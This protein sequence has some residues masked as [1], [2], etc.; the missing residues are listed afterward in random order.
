MRLDQFLKVSRLIKRRPLG[1]KMCAAG[2]VLLNG[3]KAKAARGVRIGDRIEIRR[4]RETWTVEVL[5]LPFGRIRKAE[6]SA[7][8]RTLS[9]TPVDPPWPG[10]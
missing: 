1:K 6:S 5:A 9:R 8:Y 7:L 4:E 3:T 10:G 2:R